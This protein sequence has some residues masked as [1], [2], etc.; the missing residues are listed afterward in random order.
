MGILVTGATGMLGANLVRQLVSLGE[1]P[2]VLVRPRSDR[3]GL[4]GLKL[5]EVLGDVT[6]PASLQAAM[7]G[8]TRVYHLAGA[9]RFDP[10]AET[11]LQ[12]VHVQGTRNVLQAAQTAKVRRLVH[13]S[14][15]ASV[16]HG[17]LDRP[18]HEAIEYNFR[19]DQP[20]HR[21]KREGERVALSE[22][23][24]VEVVVANPSFVLGAYDVR[25]SSGALL[26][27]VAS[28]L[29]LFYPTGGNNFV[30]AQDVARGL[31]QLMAIGRPG[32]RYILG[33]ENL[34]YRQLVTMCADEI[35]AP[36]PFLPAPEPLMRGA[37]RLGDSLG[38]LA[39]NLFKDLNS[40]FVESM[41]LPAYYTSQKAMREVGY[42][43]GPV[44]MGVRA[45]YRWFQDEGMIARDRP[46]TPVQDRMASR[47]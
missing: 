43:P 35:G 11:L 13:V 18:A 3:R 24:P 10:A 14:T 6:D 8:V 47:T 12:A 9:L 2:R 17:T 22:A 37:G 1:R 19:E 26:L 32:E 25:P 15:V 44:R 21:S 40:S 41:F 46:L 29:A 38:R 31:T 45:A 28:G 20:Y 7:R 23:G 39:P 36:A 34:T 30:A 27:F 5:E 4:R 42:Q 16:G 33:G